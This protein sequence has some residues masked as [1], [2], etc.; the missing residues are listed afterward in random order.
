MAL[1]CS[2]Y[3]Y[4]SKSRKLDLF[5]NLKGGRVKQSC[6]ETILWKDTTSVNQES[7]H[8]STWAF[9]SCFLAQIKGLRTGVWQSG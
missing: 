4:I 9:V 8:C 5:K 6:N 3:E 7:S 1:R 2:C